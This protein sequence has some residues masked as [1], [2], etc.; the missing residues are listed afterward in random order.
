MEL[1]TLENL[2]AMDQWRV[3]YLGR[4]GSLT[5]VLR[6]LSSLEVG[7]R[8]TIGAAANQAKKTLE[9][10]LERRVRQINDAALQGSASQDRLDVTL[11]GR[12]ALEGRLH[13]TTKRVREICNGFVALGVGVVEGP[14]GGGGH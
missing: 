13:S 2:E 11:P 12:Q 5:N 14:E 6:S 7:E 9:E 8:R 1:D 10:H 3:S 4:R